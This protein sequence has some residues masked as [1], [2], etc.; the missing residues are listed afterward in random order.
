[1]NG[2][3]KKPD[4]RK[5]QKRGIIAAFSVMAVIVLVWYVIIPAVGT[6]MEKLKPKEETSDYM[7]R[8]VS[9]IFYPARYGEDVYADEEYMQ[10]DRQI[11]Y[12]IGGDTYLIS[13]G[14]YA[15]Y[16]APLVLFS[17]Y[18]DTVINGRYKELD[19]YFTDYYFENQQN[20]EKFAPQKI[21]D[22]SV[23]LVSSKTEDGATTYCFRVGFKIYKNDGTFRNDIDSDKA[24]PVYYE[25]I[26]DSDGNAL[27]NYIGAARRD[28][29]AK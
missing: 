23:E 25:V 1:M 20:K 17:E 4:V 5:K 29:S 3:E 15:Q 7:D 2:E 26:E 12:K 16:G 22:I 11:S 9:Y 18:F 27:I 21:Y 14:D 6:L 19:K 10:K 28:I 24:R 8:V 13:D